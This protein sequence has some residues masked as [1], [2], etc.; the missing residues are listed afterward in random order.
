YVFLSPDDYD[1]SYAD[2]V[3]TED[4]EITLDG[5]PLKTTF[6]KVGTAGLG[7]YR[8]KLGAGKG[9]AHVL[10]A[11]KPVGVQV[12]GYGD[13]TSY[14]YPAGLNL[15]LIAPPPPPPK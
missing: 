7:I 9:G 4:A 13:N 3:G 2:I 6:Q 10:T 15:K 12:I 8:V 5:A 1:V 11:K 14:Q